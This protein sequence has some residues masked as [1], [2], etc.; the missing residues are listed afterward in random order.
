MILP[1]GSTVHENL[2]TVFIDLN[3][4]LQ[5]LKEDNFTGYLQ[6]SF[7]DYE[8]ILFLESGEIVNAIEETQGTRRGGEEAV[9]NIILR[10]KQKD[11][12]IN[13]YR[14][15]P[16]MVT[17][18]ASTSMKEATYKELSTDFTSLDKLIDKL[19]KENHSGYIDI[20]LHDNKGGGIIFFQEGKVVEAVLSDEKFDGAEKYGRDMLQ[21]IIQDVQKIGATFN[22]YRSELE[23][24]SKR[25]GISQPLEFQEVVEVMQEVIKT[26]EVLVDDELRS[27]KG[28]FR[29]G[30]K[31]ARVEKSEDYPFLD[32]FEAEFEYSKGEITFSGKVSTEVFL[33]GLK[34]CIDLTLDSI[35]VSTPKEVLYEKIRSDLK[36]ILA[37][38]EEKIDG[39]GLKSIMPEIF[40][41]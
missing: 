18:L 33:R 31:Q 7:W 4:F 24:G 21:E 36:P 32:P 10:S 12:R 11:G 41:S 20:S 22:V 6:V 2:R 9:E 14:L 26:I 19:T 37:R 17:I 5:T 35:S 39:F 34:D 3:N 25:A 23:S 8:G 28:S 40:S 30:F 15:V 27:G 13:V 1:K 16:E 38:F 29:D